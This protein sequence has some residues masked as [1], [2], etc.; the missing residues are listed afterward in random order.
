MTFLVKFPKH[1]LHTAQKPN[2]FYFFKA[3]EG[4]DV[5]GVLT[6]MTLGM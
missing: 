6:V 4:A 3:Q 5:S 2:G 1:G